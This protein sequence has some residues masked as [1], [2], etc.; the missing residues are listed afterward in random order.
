[1]CM[2]LVHNTMLTHKLGVV[3]D[4][5]RLWH[6]NDG[7]VRELVDESRVVGLEA[8]QLAHVAA[9]VEKKN[10][11]AKVPL[12]VLQRDAQPNLTQRQEKYGVG[13]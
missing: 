6:M 2:S 5:N 7:V 3:G 11:V 4:C 9:A 1:M 13:S 8:P 12:L 10:A